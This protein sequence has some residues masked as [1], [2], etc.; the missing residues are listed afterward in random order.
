MQ[1]DKIRALLTSQKS[2][3]IA[4]YS[5]KWLI[6]KNTNKANYL[7]QWRISELSCS[8]DT[9]LKNILAVSNNVHSILTY[10]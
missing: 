9:T 1:K 5:L 10:P 3:S 4:I 6:K 2:Y 7:Q 8:G